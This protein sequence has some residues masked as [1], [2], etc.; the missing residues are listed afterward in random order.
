[1]NGGE[2]DVAMPKGAYGTEAAMVYDPKHD[3]SVLLL[4]AGFSGSMQT[5]LFRFDPKTAK[6]K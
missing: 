5:F 2:L 3:V 1:M 6:Y 4:P